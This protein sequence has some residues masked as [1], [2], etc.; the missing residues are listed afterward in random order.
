MLKISTRSTY[1][2]RALQFIARQDSSKAI[3]ISA[4]SDQENI[5]LPYLEQ[6]FSKLKKA[7]I[8]QSL[9]GPQGGILLSKNP[10]QITMADIVI[11]LEGPLNPV[12]CSIPAKRGP[13]CHDKD[14]CESRFICCELDG[15]ILKILRKHTVASLTGKTSLPEELV[16]SD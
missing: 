11:A 5:P 1:A 2:I 6:I 7:G 16:T 10:D 8:I 4:I 14:G 15:A 13:D 12:L 3:K 9:R